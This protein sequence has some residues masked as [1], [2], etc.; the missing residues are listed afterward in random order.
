MFFKRARQHTQHHQCCSIMKDFRIKF[1]TRRRVCL[2]GWGV[3]RGSCGTVTR[4][5][6]WLTISKHHSIHVSL[7][8]F[9]Y[10]RVIY[11]I[12]TSNDYDVFRESVA[13]NKVRHEGDERERDDRTP[14]R[15]KA[16]HKDGG[17][18]Q[19]LLRNNRMAENTL[20]PCLMLLLSVCLS[21]WPRLMRPPRILCRKVYVRPPHHQDFFPCGTFCQL[22]PDV[23]SGVHETATNRVGNSTIIIIFHLVRLF[24]RKEYGSDCHD[25]FITLGEPRPHPSC[26]RFVVIYR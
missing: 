5:A 1:F 10:V 17:E 13:L 6:W 21:V 22:T 26:S 2:A 16:R 8:F 9:V 15:D 3:C 19:K 24:L 25:V 4:L 23:A 18:I 7:V 12:L 11:F 20:V 14:S